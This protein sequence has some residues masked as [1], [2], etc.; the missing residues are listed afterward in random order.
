[1]SRATGGSK[2]DQVDRTG[3]ELLETLSDDERR[4]IEEI[5]SQII[6]RI[7]KRNPSAMIGMP[8]AMELIT[9]LG[10]FIYV[11]TAVIK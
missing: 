9:Q 8:M 2:R 7:K 10:R 1:M 6:E 5:A 4:E 11:K 3:F